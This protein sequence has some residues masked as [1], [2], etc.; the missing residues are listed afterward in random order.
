M[1]ELQNV[2]TK[3]KNSNKELHDRCETEFEALQ[4]NYGYLFEFWILSFEFWIVGKADCE[5]FNFEFWFRYSQFNIEQILMR[6]AP[7][8]TLKIAHRAQLNIQQLQRY[9]LAQ[10]MSRV[11]GNLI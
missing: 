3:F 2:I 4:T 1:E 7:N 10:A 6:T 11:K 8:S 9:N 5:L